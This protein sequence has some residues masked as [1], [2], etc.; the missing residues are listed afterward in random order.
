MSLFTIDS[1]RAIEIKGEISPIL[2]AVFSASIANDQLVI[3]GI[4]NKVFRILGIIA[5]SSSSTTSVITFKSASGGNIILAPIAVPMNTNGGVFQLPLELT[6]YA[7]TNVGEGLYADVATSGVNA[8]IFY[9]KH[10]Q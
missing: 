7:S 9:I 10:N 6:G 1:L 3:S 5:Q 2:T 4:S 8:S